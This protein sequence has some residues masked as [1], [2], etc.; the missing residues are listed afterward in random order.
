[1]GKSSNKDRAEEIAQD[2]SLSNKVME[3]WEMLKDW[4]K[5]EGLTCLFGILGNENKREQYLKR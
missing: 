2:V 3:L 1:M 5:G 4:R